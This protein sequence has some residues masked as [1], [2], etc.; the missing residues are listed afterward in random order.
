[1][2]HIPMLPELIA[3]FACCVAAIFF[4]LRINLPAIVGVLITGIVVGPSGFGIVS[5]VHAVEG[6]AELGVI[7]LMFTIGLELSLGEL[8]ALKKPVLIGGGLQVLLT[9]VL[10]FELDSRYGSSTGSAVLSGFLVALSSTA[11]VIK[12]L[13]E[14]SELSAPHGR[15]ALAVLIFQD[16]IVAPMM[17]LVPYLASDSPDMGRSLLMLAVKSVGVLGVIWVL[18]RYVV[19]RLLLAVLRTRSRE[20][21]LLCV[22]V[23][24]LAIAMFTAWVGLSISLGAFLAGLIIAQTDYA[25]AALEG[26]HPFRDVFTSL[27]FVSI[28]MLLDLNFMW[29]NLPLVLGTAGIVLVLKSM[30][31]GGASMALGYPLRVAVLVGLSLSQVGEFSF[32]LAKVGSDAGLLSQERYQL[33]LAVSIL[34][35]LAAP[36]CIQGSH[37]LSRMVSGIPGLGKWRERT[38]AQNG[39]ISGLKDHLIIVGF[40]LGGRQLANTAKSAAIPYCVV[41]M[42]PDTV[43]MEREKGEPIRHGD[44]GLPEVL[45][46]LGVEKAKVVAVVVADPVSARRVTQ[47]A[48]SINPAVTMVVRTRFV[49]EVEPLMALGAD[50]VVA[51]EFETS[52]EIFA[53]VLRTYLVPHATIEQFASQVREEGYQVLRRGEPMHNPMAMLDKSFSGFEV[54]G[55]TVE[56]GALLDG[57]TLIESELRRKH[58]LT[59]VAVQ[60]GGKIYANPDGSFRLK[61]GDVAYLFASQEDVAAHRGLFQVRRKAWAEASG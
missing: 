54:S 45:R 19:P 10:F 32:V 51:E 34:T 48:K 27:F 17:L 60:R 29:E 39:V 53:R 41:E 36:F 24:C 13:Q 6:I 46:H 56:A 42:N 55:L 12:L 43:R 57:K 3:V 52:L 58:G 28:G 15:I 47:V 49:A 2:P 18:A 37:V 31:A 40:G 4:C 33:F 9:I 30:V 5:D 16:I 8:K 26:V 50:H 11:I 22:L 21:F 38:L 35:M 20:L 14:R 44:A 61:A 1:V 25:L 59:V 7:L 23:L